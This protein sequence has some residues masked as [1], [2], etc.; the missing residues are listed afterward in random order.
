MIRFERHWAMPNKETFRIPPIK[1]LLEEEITP[2]NKR[3]YIIG[4]FNTL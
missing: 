3:K 2:G 1:Q 4:G